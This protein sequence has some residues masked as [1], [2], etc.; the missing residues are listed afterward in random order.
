[1]AFR[2]TA[3]LMAATLCAAGGSFIVDLPASLAAPGAAP[4]NSRPPAKTAP[5]AKQDAQTA[6][7][8]EKEREKAG[9]LLRAID[10]ILEKASKHRHES[11]K[12][13]SKSDYLV[14][15]P[16]WTET[17]EDRQDTIRE[18]LDSALAV[19]TDAPIVE[20]Q[21]EISAR[22]KTIRELERQI[23]QL[24]EQ[25][26]D[27]PKDGLLAG[28][29]TETEG[30]ITS[31][32]KELKARIE[33]NRKD[34]AA[35]KAKIH[36]ALKD[37]GVEISKEQLDLLIGSVL[38][39]DL[40]RLVSAF[41]AARHIDNRLGLL[42][43][44]N[45]ENLDAARRYFG[46]HAA[47]FAMLLHAQDSLVMKIDRIYLRRL[48]VII[49]DIRNARAETTRMLGEN[50]REDQRRALMANHKA[51]KFSEQVA[52]FYRDY[53]KTQREQIV[54]ARERTIRDLRIADNTYETVEA[55]FQLRALIEDA[56]TSFE[57]I[58]KLEAPGF[59]QVFKNK[60]LRK[61]FENLTR[62]LGPTS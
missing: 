20:L 21:K 13:P 34:I 18:L 7:R 48:R 59:D 60:Q 14:A 56:R 36:K 41:E 9:R 54:G 15:V 31:N 8:A 24:R 16:P 28:I 25:R 38:S 40:I 53:L 46:M 26:L 61:E 22:H 43:D 50:N 19:V 27:A 29:L 10:T 51:Q 12:L 35:A 58:R 30:T 5:P 47:L 17:R 55:S 2:R 6:D 33:E 57:A 52:I 44:Q 11:F 37:S 1:M 23:T 42:M 45:N 39:S 3:F 62:K 32:I 4:D 49:E